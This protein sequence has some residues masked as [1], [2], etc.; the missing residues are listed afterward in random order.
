MKIIRKKPIF[1][2]NLFPKI[3]IQIMTIK[4]KNFACASHS[5]WFDASEFKFGVD[6]ERYLKK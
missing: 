4:K 2:K 6:A 5:L 3:Y 1:R